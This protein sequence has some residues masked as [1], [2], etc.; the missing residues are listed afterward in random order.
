MI[1]LPVTLTAAAAAAFINF[2]LG[3]RVARIRTAEKI[4][5][6][7]GGNLRLI[8]RMRAQLNFAEYTPIVLI[9][10]GLVELA[11]GSNLYLWIV[12]LVYV[13][14]RVLHG[15][16]MDGVRAGREIGTAT[17]MLTMIGLAVYAALITY[18]VA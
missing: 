9:L 1:L 18:G 12:A 10:L 2:W 14:G 3:L 8:A 11:R 7:D 15:F 16:G 4:S 5:V 6:G 17:T 13:I